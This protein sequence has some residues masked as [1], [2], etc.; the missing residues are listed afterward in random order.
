M[1]LS[2]AAEGVERLGEVEAWAQEALAA[3]AGSR[4]ERL[5]LRAFG[6]AR[7]LGGRPV[8]D[9]CERFAAASP[10]A[11]QLVDSPEPV[12]ALRL[13]WRGDLVRA[14]ETL[15]RFLQLADE[16]GESVSYAWMRLNLCE[17]GLR[18]ADWATVSRLLDEWA[19]S[20]DEDLL[21]TPTYQRCRA[22]VAAGRGLGGEARRWATPA[23][24]AAEPLGFRWQVL[25][26][27]RALG[28]AAL[29]AHEPQV[30]AEHLRSVWEHT[31]REGID[32][33][34]AFPVAPELVGA[35][36]ELGELTEAQA[37]AGRLRELAEEQEHPWGL[38]A[39]RR[40]AA[41]LRLPDD[42]DAL[43][44]AAGDY[45]RL[46]LR[47]D[48]AHTLLA[49]GRGLRRHRKW[50][51]ARDALERAAA[52]FD[53]LDSPG[54]A[55]E[56]RSELARVGARRP[57]PSGELT[58]AERRVVELAADGSSNKEIALALFVSVRTVEAHLS[59]AYAKLGVRSRAQLASRLV[60]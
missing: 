47:G 22:L 54:W 20:A 24:Q 55:D 21:V 53:A 25:E 4:V 36:A 13:V 12:A 42:A 46:G 44:E 35:L 37:V 14:R 33:P 10:G 56:V 2:T 17:L 43:A 3:H 30:A 38:A 49:L 18:A 28:I 40:C 27:R 9:V 39:A 51:V 26:A 19:E 45:E 1:A 32:E 8:D 58:P 34:G 23:L 31:V 48:A 29:L 15:T 11:V 60:Q 52:A 59:H 6:W 41:L 50:G 16:R 5:A 7:S 57:T